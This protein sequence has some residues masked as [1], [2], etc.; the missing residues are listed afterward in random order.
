MS[1]KSESQTSP[2]DLEVTSDGPVRIVTLNRPHRRNALSKGLIQGLSNALVEA[3][4][5]DDVRVIVLSGTGE[6]AFCAGLDL[7]EMHE[8]DQTDSRLRSPA[9]DAMRSVYE[10]AS[11]VRKPMIAALNGSA[12]AGGFELALS[13]DLRI[14]HPAALFGFPEATIGMGAHFGSVVLA[15]RMPL[16][17][18]LEMLYTGEL[19]SA[20][21][22]QQ[23]GLLN[24]LVGADE[25]MPV[26][27]ALAQRIARNAPI[28]LR[29]MKAMALRGLELPLATALRLDIGP[30]PY[31]SE[32]RQEGVRA[33]MEGREPVFRG[34]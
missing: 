34:R 12:V 25:V 29:R 8:Q 32:D 16:C 15:R 2:S 24:R 17:F 3:D 28:S 31:S 19:V 21:R 4:E 13:C 14:S 22:A 23:L 7:K 26:S 10:I 6:R 33:W 18:A 20:E 27:V 5:S 9:S 30:S 11:E 1:I